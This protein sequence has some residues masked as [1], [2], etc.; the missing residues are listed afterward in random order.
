[1][2]TVD[3]LSLFIW[4]QWLTMTLSTQS[5]PLASFAW[6]LDMCERGRLTLCIDNIVIS[7][8]YV[9]Q[10]THNFGSMHKCDIEY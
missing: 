9:S 7:V 10:A 8:Q 2:C 4:K 5:H 3:S 1:M 6:T